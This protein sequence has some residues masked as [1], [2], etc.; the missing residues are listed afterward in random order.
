MC[1]SA[2][3]I[4]V[5]DTAEHSTPGT[6]FPGLKP[7]N[8]FGGN[9]WTSNQYISQSRTLEHATRHSYT[10]APEGRI[11]AVAFDWISTIN[12]PSG[13]A[14]VVL[15]QN[16]DVELVNASKG[17]ILAEATARND[18]Y[19]SCNGLTLTEA[20][21]APRIVSRQLQ[22]RGLDGLDA[23]YDVH[24]NQ[25]VS[26]QESDIGE[27]QTK[28]VAD[29]STILSPMAVQRDRCLRGYLFDCQKNR[30][31]LADTPRLVALWRTIGRFR[32]LA[33]DDGMVFE[34]LD[35]S[36]A[37]VTGLWS[38]R[39]IG[40]PQ[41]DLSDGLGK[42]TQ[43][44]DAISGLNEA[45][46]LPAFE[47][48]RTDFPEHRQ[49]CL[50]VCGWK[51]TTEDLEAECAELIERGRYYLA[52]VQAV[53]HNDKHLALNMLRTLVR[54]R[55]I[56]N[57]GLG[58]LLACETLNNEQKEMC[59]W[60]S[61]D[62]ED[63]ALKALLT[64]LID[65]DWRGVMKTD[66]LN[67]TYRV[68]LGLKYLIDTELSNY[69]HSETARVIKNGD[70]QGILLTGLGERSMD[71]FQTYLTRTNDLQTA[72]LATAFTNPLYVDDIRWEM[73]K[74]TYFLQM[75][76]WHAFIQ[77]TK[78]TVQHNRMSTTR[79]GR[80]L[81][82]VPHGQITL[83]CIHCQGSLARHD[84]KP[85]KN[86]SATRALGP[87]ANAGTVCPQCGRHMP[88]CAVCML[89]LG[90]PDSRSTGGVKELE[91]QEDL[92]SKFITFCASCGHGFHAHHAMSWFK[93]HAMCA[94]PDCKCM[95][96][97]K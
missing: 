12:N 47:G 43:M 55:T 36:Y 14:M 11:R 96:G 78:F 42:S 91:Q 57:T 5:V 70:L 22:G 45:K 10:P 28:S 86:G 82:D 27:L 35:L 53:L 34:E 21:L 17:F 44:R 16:R 54:E 7:Q 77:R 2:G 76:A 63:S 48:E 64:Y 89:W 93:K 81:I 85:Q 20:A 69:I 67:L 84:S 52:I 4:K 56:P 31:V 66:Y 73:W 23:S 15:R 80:R 41:R 88:R 68:A 92:M 29:L 1:S 3:E 37:G 32:Q 72:V 49:L 8:P 87:A 50:A 74:E 26:E 9:A 60:M 38:E 83:R 59:M 25:S 46:S 90:T 61:A 79:T 71:L 33:A 97:L 94:V 18:L 75:Q 51:F 95:C 30:E 13:Q 39:G 58:A 62:T 65:G 6:D 24:A 19:V 40:S